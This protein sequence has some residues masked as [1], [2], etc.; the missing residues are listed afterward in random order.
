MPH[1]VFVISMGIVFSYPSFVFAGVTSLFT[2]KV[3]ALFAQNTVSDEQ[4]RGTSQTMELFKPVVV[5]STTTNGAE[6]DQN[7]ESDALSAVSGP[8]RISTE[9]IDFP[10]TDTV[11]VYE[12]KSGD[13]IESVAKIFDVSVNTI[14]WAN[15]LPSRKITKGDTLI[16]LPITGI[17]H[18]VKKGDSI[19]TLARKYK[20]DEQDIASYNGIA[21]DATLLPG[22]TVIVPDGEIAIAQPSKVSKGKTPKKSTILNTY[23][24]S[25]PD[26]FLT[27][28]VIGARRTQGI[29]GHNGVDLAAPVGTPVLASG[30]GRVIVARTGGYNGGY[31][32]MVIISHNKGIQTVYAHLSQ[33]HV[34]SGQMVSQ[35]ETIG[36][37]GNTGRSTG[38]HLH[39]EVRGAKNPF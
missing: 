33:V 5:D 12:V 13:T 7:Q 37:V 35:G 22:D 18:T 10:M 23:A 14:M 27:R 25:A 4:P 32:S 16:I 34:V 28:P 30:S 8:L 15:N 21:V 3:K 17:K 24:N 6:I 9:D 11:S 20:A 31:G 39:F 19:T 2:G 29:H 1:I 26:G 38:S 36:A